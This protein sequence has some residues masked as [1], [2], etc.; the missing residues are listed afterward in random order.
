LAAVNQFVKDNFDWFIARLDIPPLLP[1]NDDGRSVLRTSLML[2]DLQP[3]ASPASTDFNPLRDFK[4][5]GTATFNH[6]SRNCV[7]LGV[8]DAREKQVFTDSDR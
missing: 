4:S 6:V 8:L 7:L 2:E 1:P 3:S 5:I